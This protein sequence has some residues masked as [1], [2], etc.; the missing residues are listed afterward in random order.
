[1]ARIDKI[2]EEIGWLKVIFAI[3]IATDIS[4]IAWLIQ[5]YGRVQLFLSILGVLG[6]L[7]IMYV[8]DRLDSIAR[9]KMN[10]LEDL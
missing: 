1:M 7:V 9:R 2:K 6:A 3:L 8:I 4:L 5:S 10:E